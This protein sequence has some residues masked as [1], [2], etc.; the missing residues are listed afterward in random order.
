VTAEVTPHHLLLTDELA[1][2]YDAVYKVNPPLRTQEDVLALREGLAD[3]TIDIVATDHAPHSSDSKECEWDVAA[4][5]MV[6]LE[7]A[8]SVV[9]E[10]MINTKKMDW[11]T[12]VERMSA[13]PARIGGYA[14]HGQIRVG[15]PANLTVIDTEA[16]WQVDRA[17]LASKSRNTPFH[18][19]SLPAK[20]IHTIYNGT[21][22]VGEGRLTGMKH[23]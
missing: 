22:V 2:H 17:E 1:S 6:G 9:V 11:S 14:N 20:V 8:L 4:F 7:T 19:L 23:G 18:G 16:S 21:Q 10:S 5:G 12:L 3:G 13:A 15:A